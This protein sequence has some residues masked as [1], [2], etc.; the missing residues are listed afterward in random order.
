[1]TDLL[2]RPET[3]AQPRNSYVADRPIEFEAWLYLSENIDS[4]LVK[5]VM[6][7]RMAAQYPH[8]WIFMWLATLLSQYAETRGLGVI[9]G[10]R[11]AVKIDRYNGRLPD[12]LFVR[13]E[14]AAIIHKDAIY[15]AP[16]LVIEIV[17]PSNYQSDIIA[18]ETD[19]CSIGVPEIVFV[20]PQRKQARVLRKSDADQYED[21][22]LTN[23]PLELRAMPGFQI[24]IEWIFA[25]PR[26]LTLD[27]ITR[28]LEQ[29][30]GE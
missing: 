23:G 10:S 6:V 27:V 17:S 25:E 21:F 30:A 1:M 16:D 4:E 28:L 11:T 9:L 13:A 12:I 22:S 20:D 15:G 3:N 5:G 2:I 19:Y 14:N 24:E 8:E 26:P 7:N 18:L 29:A